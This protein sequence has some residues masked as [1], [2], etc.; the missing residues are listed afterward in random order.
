MRRFYEKT[1]KWVERCIEQSTGLYCHWMPRRLG[2]TPV[3]GTPTVETMGQFLNDDLLRWQTWEEMRQMIAAKGWHKGSG[4]KM[5]EYEAQYKGREKPLWFRVWRPFAHWVNNCKETP[6]PTDVRM[7]FG[8]QSTGNNC[9]E[10]DLH[11]GRV[12]ILEKQGRYFVAVM[13]KS[14]WWGWDIIQK[15][16]IPSEE[17]YNRIILSKSGGCEWVPTSASMITELVMRKQMCLFELEADDV[18]KAATGDENRHEQFAH[19]ARQFE[20]WYVRNERRADG[21]KFYLTWKL[22]FN[23]TKAKSELAEKSKPRVLEIMRERKYDWAKRTIDVTDPSEAMA[24]ARWVA[25]NDG[26]IVIPSEDDTALRYAVMRSL[27]FVTFPDRPVTAKGGLLNGYQ[28]PG[29][30]VI[31]ARGILRADGTKVLGERHDKD[32][33]RLNAAGTERI[34]SEL[35]SRACAVVLERNEGETV[36]MDCPKAAK[37]CAGMTVTASTV[38]EILETCGG[39]GILQTAAERFGLLRKGRMVLVNGGTLWMPD[40]SIGVCFEKLLGLTGR[41]WKPKRLVQTSPIRS[42]ADSVFWKRDTLD[43]DLP[44][45]RLWREGKKLG[46]WIKDRV[47]IIRDNG[48]WYLTALPRFNNPRNTLPY[49]GSG[50]EV[51]AYFFAGDGTRRRSGMCLKTDSFEWNGMMRLAREGRLYVYRIDTGAY[52]DLLDAIYSDRNTAPCNVIASVR[53]FTDKQLT[54]RVTISANT[55]QDGRKLSGREWNAY[56]DAFPEERSREKVLWPTADGSDSPDALRDAIRRVIDTDGILMTDKPHMEA[57]LKATTG[58]L[59]PHPSTKSSIPLFQLKDRVF[60]DDGSG[61]RKGCSRQKVKGKTLVE[62]YGEGFMKEALPEFTSLIAADHIGNAKTKDYLWEKDGIS[63]KGS[64][65][66]IE[67]ELRRV[68]CSGTMGW[69]RQLIRPAHEVAVGIWMAGL[70]PAPTNAPKTRHSAPVAAP[71]PD[72]APP[73]APARE[74]RLAAL[75]ALFAEGLVTQAEYDAKKAEI[76]K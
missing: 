20:F 4:R 43:L 73:P 41:K 38:G 66:L 14:G 11:R 62:V 27:F 76:L 30:M 40:T 49:T 26:C 29:R 18:F 5:M 36:P 72:A 48:M 52:G 71:E 57:A 69:R 28:L 63:T 61:E 12:L 45:T 2:L 31:R 6:R 35:F 42:L 7:S 60:W 75:N 15:R 34:V 16:A 58:V 59:H 74:S 46:A 44:I 64:E 47:W 55:K 8:W 1:D 65:P 37:P 56:C 54:L 21:D 17:A 53:S 51:K 13:M 3:A 68:L 10:E 32:C 50:V 67:R 24:A 23:P 33:E 25:E 19:I 70:A 39:R 9:S 22:V